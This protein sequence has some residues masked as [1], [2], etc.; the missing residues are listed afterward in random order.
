MQ[1]QKKNEIYVLLTPDLGIR[2]RWLAILK[3]QPRLPPEKDP[4]HP[5]DRR[6]GGPQSWSEHLSYK[7]NP[8]PLPGIETQ[9]RSSSP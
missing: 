5:S 9:S 6:L 8:L 2:W 3:N 7:K 4:W 1:A